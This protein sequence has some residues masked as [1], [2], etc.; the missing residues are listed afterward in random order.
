MQANSKRID[1]STPPV[2]AEV[3][4]ANPVDLNVPRV[5]IL[6]FEATAK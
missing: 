3:Y 5:T 4:A 6:T 1:L 2:T